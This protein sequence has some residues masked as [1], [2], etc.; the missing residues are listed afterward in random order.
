MLSQAT[1]AVA[2]PPAATSGKDCGTPIG[3]P[4]AAGTPR[5]NATVTFDASATP[6]LR[7][8][9]ETVAEPP[10]AIGDGSTCTDAGATCRLGSVDAFT[11]S[12]VDTRL[13]F[14]ALSA[15][16]LSGSICTTTGA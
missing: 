11:V 3:T 9:I 1:E 7:T 10:W 2:C 13:L 14:S 5:K 8:T 12:G 15:N 16:A 4:P 6:V